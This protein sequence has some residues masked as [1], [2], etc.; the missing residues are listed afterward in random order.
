QTA[1][2]LRAVL[3]H[4]ADEAALRFTVAAQ[5]KL[6]ADRAAAEAFAATLT[7]VA[8]APASHSGAGAGSGSDSDSGG[9]GSGATPSAPG[10][11]LACIR[12]HE[13]DSAGGYQAVSSGGAYRG[14]YQ[15]AQS[16][17]DNTAGAAGRA[18][19]VG[20]DPASV[21]PADQ[22]AMASYLYSQ[23]GSQPWGGRC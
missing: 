19:L 3:Q 12:A 4:Q 15:F 9:S 17:W 10:D 20:A 22:D 8:A 13:S 14:A 5:L 7:R 6:D 11:S 16:T 21:S 23:A 18:D 1:E 2:Q